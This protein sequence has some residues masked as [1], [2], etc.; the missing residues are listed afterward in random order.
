[1]TGVNWALESLAKQQENLNDSQKEFI[2]T[3]IQATSKLSKTIND[4]LDVSKIEEGHFGYEFENTDIISFVDNIV[5]EAEPL[6]KQYGVKVYFERP[7][8]PSIVV[9][10]DPQKLSMVFSNLLDN[11]FKYNIENGEVIVFVERVPDEPY[12]KVSVKDTGVGV[13]AEANK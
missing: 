3:A 9:L 2:N 5:R 13:P 1:M 8:D 6:A 10:V 4:L 12:I 11:A 7:K